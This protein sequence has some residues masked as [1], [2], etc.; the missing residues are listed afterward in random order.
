MMLLATGLILSSVFAF[1]ADQ[2]SITDGKDVGKLGGIASG[3]IYIIV[4]GFCAYPITMIMKTLVGKTSK[5]LN[6]KYHFS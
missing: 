3:I 1:M 2:L 5:N 6:L 4:A